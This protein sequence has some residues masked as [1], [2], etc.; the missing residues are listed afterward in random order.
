MVEAN[1]LNCQ[2]AAERLGCTRQHIS[3]L[4]RSGE[5]TG[6]KIGRDWIVSLESVERYAAK[7]E[8]FRLP[9]VDEG[10]NTGGAERLNGARA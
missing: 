10:R 8:N 2:D 9:L 6:R 1:F 5:L 7:R 3:R 4:V